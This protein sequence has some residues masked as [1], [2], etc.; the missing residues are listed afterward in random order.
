MQLL[1]PL[2][3]ELLRLTTAFLAAGTDGAGAAVAVA[4]ATTAARERRFLSATRA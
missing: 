3:A 1:F 4:A 2:L